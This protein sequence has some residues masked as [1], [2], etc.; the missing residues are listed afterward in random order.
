MPPDCRPARLAGSRSFIAAL[1]AFV[2]SRETNSLCKG[3]DVL[4]LFPAGLGKPLGWLVNG[5]TEVPAG[6][7]RPGAALHSRKGPELQFRSM[8]LACGLVGQV[9]LP[10]TLTAVLSAL[11]QGPQKKHLVKGKPGVQEEP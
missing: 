2:L 9:C 7:Q 5:G 8:Q 11:F 10:L 3:N 4:L 6:E 1:A